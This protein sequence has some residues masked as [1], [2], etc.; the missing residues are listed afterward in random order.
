MAVSYDNQKVNKE[1]DQLSKKKDGSFVC[2]YVRKD[3]QQKIAKVNTT[4]QQNLYIKYSVIYC[5]SINETYENKTNVFGMAVYFMAFSEDDQYLMVYFQIVDNYQIR[6]NKDR[7]GNY[8]VYDRSLN[9][10]VKDWDRQKN[11]VF[12]KIKFPNH[13]SGKYQFYEGNLITSRFKNTDER[14]LQNANQSSN[15]IYLSSIKNFSEFLVMGDIEGDIHISKLKALSFD[16][17]NIAENINK[18]R[19]CQAK[20]YASHVS[21]VNQIEMDINEE[22]LFTTG[23]SDQCV[24]QWKINKGDKKWELDHVDLPLQDKNDLFFAE[25]ESRSKYTTTIEQH[26]PARDEIVDVKQKIDETYEPEL[27]LEIDRVL[28]RRAFNRRNNLFFTDNNRL[29]FPAGSILVSLTIPP[30]GE[31]LDDTCYDHYFDQ[32]FLE[33]DSENIFSVNPEISCLAISHNRK[34]VCIGTTQ[35]NA[36]LLIWELT[37]QTFMKNMTLQDCCTVLMLKYSY[38]TR[39]VACI[40]LTRNYTQVVYLIDTHTSQILGA[41]NLFYSLP[42]KIK[43]LE[44]LPTSKTEF[45]TCGLQHMTLW[46]Y[47][48]GILNFRELPIESIQ[49]GPSQDEILDRSDEEPDVEEKKDTFRV[50]FLSLLFIMDEFILTAGDDGHVIYLNNH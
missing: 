45:I 26:L 32:S 12:K 41:C 38:D 50:T 44:F 31:I 4:D 7:E 14:I 39:M 29:I 47:K 49:L 42:F 6:Q 40:A 11:A 18:N 3:S 19:L 16:R 36:Q 35:S 27:Y 21:F 23:V 34:F 8:I 9:S 1:E 48:G 10:S 5:P 22:F 46:T 30:E 33:V 2:I 37:S 15:T 13:I 17:D 43:D 24:F 20:T 28:G 25:V